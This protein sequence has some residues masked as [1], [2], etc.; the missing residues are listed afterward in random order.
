[1]ATIGP[2]DFRE[3]SRRYGAYLERTLGA[4]HVGLI[5]KWQPEDLVPGSSD[6]D[7]R[8]IL[9]ERA[10]P[11]YWLAADRGSGEIHR[12]LAE[13]NHAW[14]RILEHPPGYGLTTAEL[15]DNDWYTPEYRMWQ[16]CHG[17]TQALAP[18]GTVRPSLLDVT[19]ASIIAFVLRPSPP[20]QQ[21]GRPAAIAATK[22]STR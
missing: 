10:T 6:I 8:V 16:I 13:Q 1:M 19:A 2:D 4:A 21:L 5:A 20:L 12:Q 18:M 17:D 3:I 15:A 7:F 9:S 11:A 14:W 22:S